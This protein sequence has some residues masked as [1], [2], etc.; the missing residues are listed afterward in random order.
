[1]SEPEIW[2]SDQERFQSI[3]RNL[4]RTTKLL[5]D[6]TE[7]VG[8]LVRVWSQAMNHDAA[9]VEL[10][11]QNQTEEDRRP[12]DLG[13]RKTAFERL[14][15]IWART[16]GH[17]HEARGVPELKFIASFLEINPAQFMRIW[18][19]DPLETRIPGTWFDAL[20][21]DITRENE[22]ANT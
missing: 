11:I 17:W 2:G 12:N 9:Q 10:E 14:C 1:M 6:L 16:F 4:E 21:A 13:P 7:S 20:E 19:E 3:E 15:E 18:N 5:E 22:E 8:L